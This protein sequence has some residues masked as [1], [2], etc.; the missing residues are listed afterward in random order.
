MPDSTAMTTPTVS[1]TEIATAAGADTVGV[2]AARPFTE[3][4]EELV[5]RKQ[6]GMAG[7][8]HFTFDD[9]DTASDVSRTFPWARSLVVVGCSYLPHSPPPAA[10]GAVLARFATADHYQRV[11]EVAN[12]VS[13]EIERLGGR[14]DVLIDDNRLVDR[15]AAVRA[16][17]GW[18]GRST[19]VLAPGH[20]PWLLFGSVATDL[21]LEPTGPMR[22]SCG[23]CVACVP[24]CPTGAITPDG[25]DARLCIS[26][27]LQTGGALPRW[28]RPLVERRIYGCDD[29]LTSCPPGRPALRRPAMETTELDFAG[30]LSLDDEALVARFGWFY[31]PHRQPRFLRRNLLVAAGNSE[32]PNAVGPILDHFDHRSSLVRGHAY[33]ALARS[34][35]M[36]AWTPLR[37]RYGIETVPDARIEL[38]HSLLML[39]QNRFSAPGGI[40]ETVSQRHHRL[41]VDLTDPGL[42]DPEHIADLGQG[43]S[44]VVVKGHHETLPAGQSVDRVE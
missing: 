32:E 25:L 8:L 5:I 35:G 31:V 7:P 15:A 18:I 33:W 21:D 11:R 3:A 28:V 34:L 41:G 17:L 14:S 38:E 43:H 4:R 9:P 37:E 10:T 16:G 44:L 1:I 13:G 2:T 23:T 39:R 19:M 40:P 24:A 26:T 42:G 29:C 20:G 22:R 6:R 27:W 12:A 36:E 30:L